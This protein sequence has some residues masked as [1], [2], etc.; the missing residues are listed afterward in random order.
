MTLSNE[1][2]RRAWWTGQALAG[3]TSLDK[4][5]TNTLEVYAKGVALAC[6][7]LADAMEAEYRARLPATLKSED[8]VKPISGPDWSIAP[9]WAEWWAQDDSEIRAWFDDDEIAIYGEE[10]RTDGRFEIYTGPYVYPGDW[11]YSK[12][13]RQR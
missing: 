3:F 4:E 9:E 10:W 12:Q 1:E 6:F 7:S 8:G 13:M 5:N 11:R 2:E